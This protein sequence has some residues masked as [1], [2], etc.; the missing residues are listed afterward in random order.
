MN[1]VR[2]K[3]CGITSQKD[4]QIVIHA[5]VEAAGFIIDVPESQRSI[6]KKQAKE[7]MKKVPIFMT[8]VAVVVVK[9]PKFPIEIYKELK[10]DVIQL[11][12]FED[13]IKEIREKLPEAKIIG[14]IPANEEALTIIEETGKYLDSVL[15][16]S[17]TKGKHGG[18]G[19]THDWNLS[20]KIREK[21]YPKPLIL[22][23]GLNSQNVQKAIHKV[24]P[25]AV[26]VASGVE[27]KPGKKDTIEVN[28]FIR[29]AKRI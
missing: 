18:T 27:I 28:D 6:T 17:I 29:N 9:N 11:H 20:K 3:I 8:K 12:G 7:L 1:Y 22:A 4:L 10:P 21:I 19:K 25:Y 2:V 26:D 24:E 23:G 15:I 14:A 13:Y 16:D 5:G